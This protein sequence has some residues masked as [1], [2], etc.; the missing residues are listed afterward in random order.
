MFSSPVTIPCVCLGCLPS[1]A[2]LFPKLSS[3]TGVNDKELGRVLLSAQRP[4]Q[5][6]ERT[7]ADI[8]YRFIF[9]SQARRVGDT[10]QKC[11]GVE[12]WDPL[13]AP[14]TRAAVG[15]WAS[16]LDSWEHL[17]SGPRRRVYGMKA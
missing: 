12:S 2:G 9:G 1:V 10:A 8:Y 16:R 5:P 17:E 3:K 4:P 7:Q 15:K 6:K 14:G 11:I 13:G